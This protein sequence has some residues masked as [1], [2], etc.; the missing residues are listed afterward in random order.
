MK[1]VLYTLRSQVEKL[2]IKLNR[3]KAGIEML[4]PPSRKSVCEQ[5]DDHKEAIRKIGTNQGS[6][7][8]AE[9]VE[10][11]SLLK[12]VGHAIN[13]GNRDNPEDANETLNAAI[14]KLEALPCLGNDSESLKLCTDY[15]N[16]EMCD[17][18][19]CVCS[20]KAWCAFKTPDIS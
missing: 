9:L 10:A 15:Q 3:D 5:L 14:K 8:S 1:S 19:K 4:S 17:D 18:R 20:S 12:E 16:D 2:Q 7:N 13:F 6:G 11:I